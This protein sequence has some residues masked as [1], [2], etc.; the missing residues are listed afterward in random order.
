MRTLASA[1]FL[2]FVAGCSSSSTTGSAAP[3]GDA[4]ATDGSAAT[5]ASMPGAGGS[6]NLLMAWTG[7]YTSNVT[8]LVFANFDAAAGSRCATQTIAPSCYAIDCTGSDP[9]PTALASGAL[10]LY[11]GANVVLTSSPDANGVYTTANSS[12]MTWNAGDAIGIRSAGAAALPMFDVALTAP[13]TITLTSPF[14]DGGAVPLD[15]TQPLSVTWT[16]SAP[17]VIVA[18]SQVP[19]GTGSTTLLGSTR[20][21]CEFD[22]ASGSATVPAAAIA[23]LSAS[24]TGTT[25]LNIGGGD[26]KDTT[27]GGRALHVYAID[28]QTQV[29][30]VK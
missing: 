10:E 19:T 2:I 4:G 17:K 14:V 12:S 6:S 15:R 13:P 22:G 24:F 7:K 26:S 9:A 25:S 28:A 23:V 1:S 5:D 20:F 11:D 30:T 16:G 18:A 29:A 3:G 27:V 21:I 8:N